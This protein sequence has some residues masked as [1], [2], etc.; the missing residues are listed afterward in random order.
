MW[1]APHGRRPVHRVA[2]RQFLT[3]LGRNTFAIAVLG[4][5][6]A[7]CGGDDDSGGD[8]PTPT[9]NSSESASEPTTSGV[10]TTT[11][12]E[13]IDTSNDDG[14]ADTS[15]RWAQA[16]LGSVSAYVLVR[17]NDAAVVDTGSSGSADQIGEALAT[18]GAT[19]DDVRHVVL[20]HSH[21]DHIGSL[22]AVLELTSG[23]AAYA[24]TLDIP[25]ISA[26]ID[27]TAVGS[28]D[29]VFGLE[30]IDTPG[31]TP[32]S[33][34]VF[35]H[36]IG[37]LVAGDALNGTADGTGLTGP[38]PTYTPDMDTANMS[39]VELAGLAPNAVAMGHGQPVES[40]ADSLLSALAAGL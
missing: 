28:G 7:A 35:D 26:P 6:V 23:A 34:S 1:L 5:F 20:T 29:D 38:N 22:P 30:V 39:V 4:G 10:A 8:E 37:L 18:L 13:T 11:A 32:G 21:P 33:I 9:T 2:R 16:Q 25:N 14:V 17:G 24:G 31:H 3:D 15:L 27:I 12:G 36:G 40:D 19:F